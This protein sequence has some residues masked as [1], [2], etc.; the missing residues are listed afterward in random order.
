MREGRR[1]NF[2]SLSKQTERDSQLNRLS[3]IFWRSST[4]IRRK[5][6]FP[7]KACETLDGDSVSLENQE[8]QQLEVACSQSTGWGQLPRG[9]EGESWSFC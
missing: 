9:D 6:K 8:S 7:S 2:V 4:T 5:F 1:K 3:C